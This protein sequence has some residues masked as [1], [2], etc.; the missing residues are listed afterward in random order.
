MET[1]SGDLDLY[2][3]TFPVTDSDN[4]WRSPPVQFA[5]T[6]ASYAT[7]TDTKLII[8]KSFSW[9]GAVYFEED[10]TGP[11]MNFV[12]PGSWEPHIWITTNVNGVNRLYAS[13]FYPPQ[14]YLR[15]TTSLQ[16]N[17]WYILAVSWD[18]DNSL[19]SMWV[20]GEHHE[21]GPIPTNLGSPVGVDTVYMGSL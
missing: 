3:V 11:L 19:I 21:T 8:T 16:K 5:G 9:M 6:D 4:Q 12:D 14:V 18:Y 17:T 7:T 2:G 13:A 1:G 20:N 10:V 15:H